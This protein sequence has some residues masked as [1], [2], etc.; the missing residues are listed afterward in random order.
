MMVKV[1]IQVWSTF[2]LFSLN[3]GVT[4]SGVNK[5]QFNRQQPQHQQQQQFDLNGF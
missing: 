5:N 3:G 2:D 4:T 1:H